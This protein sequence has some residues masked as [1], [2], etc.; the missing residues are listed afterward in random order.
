MLDDGHQASIAPFA[1]YQQVLCERLLS[2][3]SVLHPLIRA[4]VLVALQQRGKLLASFAYQYQRSSIPDGSWSLV[5]LLV[6][7]HIAPAVDAFI[8]NTV[9]VALECF[10]CA[11]D[12]LDDVEDEDQTSLGLTLGVPRMLNVS[13]TLLAL[14]QRA[15]I[16]LSP[17]GAPSWLLLRLLEAFQQSTL[18]ATAG[19]HKDLLAEQRSVFTI[20]T[21]DC[22]A[23]AAE[24]AGA[25]LRLACNVGAMCAGAEKEECEMFSAL[26]EFLGIAHQLDNDSHDLYH[27]LQ[28]DSS[29][30]YIKTEPVVKNVKTDLI[31]QKKTLPVVFAARSRSTLQKHLPLSDSERQRATHDSLQE[32]IIATWGISLLYKERARECLQ[33]IEAR[34]PVSRLLRLL[35][36]F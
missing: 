30:L 3:L 14:S 20:T 8:V 5:V 7:L 25:L 35:L 31:R 19:Q 23:V 4:D 34:R 33:E 32:G 10:I 2:L 26:G 15:L 12:L 28:R 1:S 18:T 29:P 27:I 13:T 36:G 9:A 22:I 24:K 21:E 17:Y 11:L 6:A 16:S